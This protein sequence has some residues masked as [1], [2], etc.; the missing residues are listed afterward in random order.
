[1][2]IF[3]TLHAISAK[4][5]MGKGTMRS[6]TLLALPGCMSS[7]IYSVQDTFLV[8]NLAIDRLYGQ[9]SY[10]GARYFQLQIVTDDG[11][12]ITCSAG[13]LIIADASIDNIGPSDLIIVSSA[14]IASFDDQQI[15]DYLLQQQTNITWLK[16]Q[17]QQGT[18]IAS[19]CTGSFMLAEA[20]LFKNKEATSHWLLEKAFK[21]RYPHIRYNN[22]P[23]VLEYE[24]LLCGAAF[25]AFI[26]LSLRLIERFSTREI[27]SR[28][29]KIMLADPYREL[30]TPFHGRSF[31]KQHNDNE[32][33]KA[34]EWMESHYSTSL[35]IDDIAAQ[36]SM[37]ARNFKRR[38]KQA[39]G[40]SPL[41][42]LQ[43]LRIEACKH[44]LEMTRLPSYE[45]IWKVGYEDQS[46]FRRLFKKHT[47]LTMDNYRK[48]FAPS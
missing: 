18:T 5:T 7:S 3:D 34:Q 20:G 22:K 47:G 12:P 42:Y 25:T 38:F 28:C 26:D 16:Q 36:F 37:G 11:K 33:L 39:T 8:A 45:I 30:Q 21:K 14:F 13:Q 1:M 40:E 29:A 15:D 41:A 23:V 31:E 24:L 10:E 2:V 32:V 44:Q 9:D 19:A 35:L 43:Q 27:A 17:Y 48:Q 6:I 46:S 4:L